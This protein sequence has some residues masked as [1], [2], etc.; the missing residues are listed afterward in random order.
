MDR[1]GDEELTKRVVV[2]DDDAVILLSCEQVLS[3]AGYIVEVF[4]RGEPGLERVR[5][6]PPPVLVV[7]LKMPGMDGFE[8][9]RE[10][11]THAPEVIIVVI[12]GYA[13]IATAVEAMKLGA[14]DFLPKPFTPDELRLIVGRGFERWALAR[15]SERLKK[16][17]E[18]AERRF[19]AFVSHQLKTPAV[20][21]KQY[22][23]VMLHTN[24]DQL[25]EQALQWIERCQVRLGE[26]FSLIDDWLALSRLE[27]GELVRKEEKSDVCRVAR[28]VIERLRP[29]ASKSEVE[30]HEFFAEEGIWVRG[31]E[32]S[33]CVLL[34]NLISNAIK[35]NVRGGRVE[36]ISSKQEGQ[37]VLEVRDT[38]IGIAEEFL[39]RLGEEFFRVRDET[40]RHIQG[41]G[42]GL[43]ICRKIVEELGGKMTVESKVGVGTVFRV[44]LPAANSISEPAKEA[45]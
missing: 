39:P 32:R 8:V 23:D 1:K 19:L 6:F 15:E 10:V 20:A 40:T 21:V 14:Y 12:T 29:L 4:D 3:R 45:Q 27:R 11:R 18:A 26:M 43:T 25:P 38:G 33:I 31:D 44:I 28:D 22:L 13:T 9:I 16:Q 5:Q 42:L 35:Y 41:T 37:V 7:D 36:V 30:I 17:K 24:R 34:E 2:I